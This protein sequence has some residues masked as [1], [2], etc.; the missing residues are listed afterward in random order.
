MRYI[1]GFSPDHEVKIVGGFQ[2]VVHFGLVVSTTQTML[3][4]MNYTHYCIVGGG[5]GGDRDYIIVQY[6]KRGIVEI[7]KQ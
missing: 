3:R 2:N 5:G 4:G 7:N 6:M 1:P